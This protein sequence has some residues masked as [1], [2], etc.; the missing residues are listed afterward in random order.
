MALGFVLIKVISGYESEVY[1][2]LNG[3]P[4]ITELHPL[5]GEY[6]IIVK[7]STEDF[8]KLGNII[9][10][11]IRIIEGILDTKTLTVTK[12]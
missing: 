3:F 12:F 9:V 2:K 4:E 5:F 10:T 1:N 7:I 6:D 11:K 8:E